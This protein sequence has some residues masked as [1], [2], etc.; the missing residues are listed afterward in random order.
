VLTVESVLVAP[1]LTVARRAHV[2]GIMLSGGVRAL[3]DGHDV[4]F[5]NVVT[6]IAT[7]GRLLWL[8]LLESFFLGLDWLLLEREFLLL[9]LDKLLLDEVL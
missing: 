1:E 7:V 3:G 8:D 2:L 9:F 6:V 5:L 4:S